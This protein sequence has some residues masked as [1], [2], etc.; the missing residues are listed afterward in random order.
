MNIKLTTKD[1]FILLCVKEMIEKDFRNRVCVRTLEMK[2][3]I[4][5]NK[6]RNGFRQEFGITIFGYRVQQQLHY[7]CELLM[8]PDYT[9]Q[10]VAIRAGF[11]DISTFNRRFRQKFFMTPTEWRQKFMSIRVSGFR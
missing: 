10:E 5:E 2:F 6:L 3:G 8:D 9:V 7:A 11:K 4:N 1:R